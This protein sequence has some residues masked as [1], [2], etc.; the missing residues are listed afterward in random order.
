MCPPENIYK[1]FGRRIDNIKNLK[2]IR[3]V[4]KLWEILFNYKIK[5]MN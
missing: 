2:N 3:E 1:L 4:I 5:E